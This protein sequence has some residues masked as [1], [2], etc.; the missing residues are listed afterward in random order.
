MSLAQGIPLLISAGL[1]SSLSDSKGRKPFVLVSN[2]G[3]FLKALLM[4]VAVRFQWNIYIF[5][6]FSFIDGCCGSWVTQ[7]SLAMAMV[8]DLTNVGKSRSFLIAMVGF[9]ISMG[10]ASGS[11]VSGFIIHQLGF[12]WGL[13]I[14]S[15]TGLV[16]MIILYF[17]EETL[18]ENKR[19]RF[20]CNIQAYFKNLIQF[21]IKDDPLNRTS[22]KWR[23]VL[24]LSAFVCIVLPR[25]GSF[26]VEIYY[27]MDTP[28]CFKPVV[29]GMFQTSKTIVS[30]SVILLGIKVL[31][32]KLNDETIAL[33]GSVSSVVSF[34][35][36]GVAPST[37]FLIIASVIGAFGL[38]PLPLIRS[39]MSKMTP[40]HKQGTMYAGIAIVENIC[41]CV[42][43]VMGSSIYSVT[44][45]V[46][47]GIVF[48][49]FSS[50]LFLA[51]VLLVFLI[52]SSRQ[53]RNGYEVIQD[54]VEEDSISNKYINVT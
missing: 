48:F 13:A 36:I 49:V 17:I 25:L 43:S 47:R 29:I 44:V 4:C 19:I 9:M 22:T 30:D 38:S 31:Q 23:Y 26:S 7:I 15:M 54:S 8:S 34:I 32:N 11:F 2:I 45:N 21:Y 1:F 18:H 24:S 16:P 50:F 5:V 53:R 3:I 6:I 37:S 42:G 27:I 14:S 33:I 39:I 35:M 10:Y 28:F 20:D 12:T 51:S 46:D 41:A 40:L 52:L